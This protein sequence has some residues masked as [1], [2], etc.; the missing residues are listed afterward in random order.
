M[1]PVTTGFFLYFGI[2]VY[3]GLWQ[4]HISISVKSKYTCASNESAFKG[5]KIFEKANQFMRF[6]T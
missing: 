4:K 2:R 3:L 6:K 1:Y 5:I